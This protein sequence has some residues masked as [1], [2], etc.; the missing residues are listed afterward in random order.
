[1][2]LLIWNR[3]GHKM[4]VIFSG[5][6]TW[7][8][9]YTW[10]L[11]SSVWKIFT[12]WK[13]YIFH[14]FLW[15]SFNCIIYIVISFL[16]AEGILQKIFLFNLYFIVLIYKREIKSKIWQKIF[17]AKISVNE[18]FL[19]CTMFLNFCYIVFQYNKTLQIWT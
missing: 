8:V 12:L 3:L 16:Y 10:I 1:M 5:F 2:N 6:I 15:F 14:Y 13:R 18:I 7:I 17:Y 4:S 11:F 9:S 19:I